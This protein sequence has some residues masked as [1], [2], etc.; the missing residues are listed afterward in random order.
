MSNAQ[1]KNLVERLREKRCKIN[2]CDST[3]RGARGLCNKHYHTFRKYGDALAAKTYR[4][5]GTGT[6]SRGYTIRVANTKRSPEHRL[7]AEKAISKALPLGVTIHHVDEDRSNNANQNLVV[8]N[9][10]YHSLLHQRM[11]AL[12]SCG[13]AD[14]R[15]CSYCKRYDSPENLFVRQKTAHHRAC[16][17]AYCVNKRPEKGT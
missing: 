2:G 11:N 17:N 16:R 3:I 12:K 6:V 10:A 13:H 8:C 4:P 7:V 5:R 9:Q 15:R 14:W 1:D